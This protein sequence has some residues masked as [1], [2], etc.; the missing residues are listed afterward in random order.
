MSLTDSK[1]KTLIGNSISRANKI[2]LCS[3]WNIEWRFQNGE[4]FDEHGVMPGRMEFLIDNEWR[5]AQSWDEDV[6]SKLLDNKK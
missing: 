3:G 2:H 6:K 5:V 1:R 4:W